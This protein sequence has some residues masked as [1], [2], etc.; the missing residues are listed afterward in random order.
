MLEWTA[1]CQAEGR[2]TASLTD[3]P[4]FSSVP[5]DHNLQLIKTF[6]TTFILPPK[7]SIQHMNRV[8]KQT[9]KQNKNKRPRDK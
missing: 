2:K 9:K 4:L 8:I 7:W 5:L 1:L 6:N 3:L